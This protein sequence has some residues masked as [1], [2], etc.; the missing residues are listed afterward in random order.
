MCNNLWKSTYIISES[1]P[2]LG[3]LKENFKDI[4]DN[5]PKNFS[6][7]ELLDAWVTIE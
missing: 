3:R 7:T 5:L 4:M 1:T 2:Y 6:L